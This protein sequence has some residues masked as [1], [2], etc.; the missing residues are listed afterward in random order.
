[1]I[2]QHTNY[3]ASFSVKDPD[4]EVIHRFRSIVFDWLKKKETDR[5]LRDEGAFKKF[6]FRSKLD[7]LW[8]TRSSVSTNTFLDDEDV[9]WAMQYQEKKP[10][11]KMFWYTDIGLSV[12]D[13]TLSINVRI[14]YAWNVEDLSHNRIDPRATIPNFV[15]RFFEEAARSNWHVFSQNETFRISEKPYPISKI[16]EGKSLSNW[17]MNPERQ[18]PLIVFNGRA[19][20]KEAVSLSRD[21]VGKA[22]IIVIDDNRD[23]ADELTEHLPFEFR[24]PFNKFR[25][26]FRIHSKNPRPERHRWF[27][28]TDPEYRAQREALI[29]SLLRNHTVTTIGGARSIETIA[30]VS[31]KISLSR[32]RELGNGAPENAEQLAAFEELLSEAQEEISKYREEAEYFASEHTSLEAQLTE[33]KYDFEGKLRAL[34]ASGEGPEKSLPILSSLPKTIGDC[35]DAI[36]PYITDRVVI[37]PQ[38]KET[39]YNYQRC[40]LLDDCWKMLL[41]LHD[42]LHP[43]KFEEEALNESTFL[44]RTGITY[45]KT[46]GK[47]TKNNA[48]FAALRRFEFEGETLEMWPHL[49][50]GQKGDKIL[51]IYFAFH[52]PSRRI[53]VGHIGPHIDNATTRNL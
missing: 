44:A 33:Q 14:A 18:F 53:I 42:T 24:V 13:G 21:L 4:K 6:S 26:F 39:A 41:A 22:N 32:L 45:A 29:N 49:K 27:S 47:T 8:N 20:V 34:Q 9:S 51:R 23:L 37:L 11:G 35:V 40:P 38:A 28:S 15:R 46:E 16:G 12:Q 52:E 43:L 48:K 7:N 19:L 30:D 3:Q 5:Q 36:E 1:M 31:R 2:N 50:V 10:G 25:V 17:I